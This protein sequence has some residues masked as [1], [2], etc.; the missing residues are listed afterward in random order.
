MSY[1]TSL[2]YT[3]PYD[4]SIFYVYDILTF[5]MTKHS[6]NLKNI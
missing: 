3:N 4:I 2:S 1:D 6:K 5:K